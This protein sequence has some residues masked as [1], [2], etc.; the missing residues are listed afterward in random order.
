VGA[1]GVVAM[2]QV[3]MKTVSALPLIEPSFV[4]VTLCVIAVPGYICVVFTKSASQ[5]VLTL[6]E[7]PAPYEKQVALVFTLLPNVNVPDEFLP[8]VFCV[9]EFRRAKVPVIVKQLTAPTTVKLSSIFF[10][11]H[12]DDRWPECSLLIGRCA[13]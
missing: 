10:R 11:C 13:R 6:P 1:P 9:S 4:I 3:G 2:V 7:L 12:M 8:R 5:F